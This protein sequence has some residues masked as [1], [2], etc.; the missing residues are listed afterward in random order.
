[1]PI[2]WINS[3]RCSLSWIMNNLSSLQKSEFI[4]NIEKITF[5]ASNDRKTHNAKQELLSQIN[6]LRISISGK[7][8]F[9]IDRPFM[10]EVSLVHRFN[11]IADF[12]MCAYTSQMVVTCCTYAIIFIQLNTT[13]GNTSWTD[14][15]WMACDVS[16]YPVSSLDFSV[17]FNAIEFTFI[18]SHFQKN[19]LIY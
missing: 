8:F 13:N 9:A 1:M 11:R 7:E 6:D 17:A 18:E 2:R 19:K 5:W 4:R 3:F 14:R 16:K 12:K 15:E 10:A